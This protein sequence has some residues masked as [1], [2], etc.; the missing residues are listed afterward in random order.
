[1]STA[2]KARVAASN[3]DTEA[4]QTRLNIN[5][6]NQTAKVLRE[7]AKANGVTVTEAVRRLIGIGTI[8]TKAEGEGKDI[9]L[10]SEAGTERIVFTY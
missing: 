9:L 10:R 1:M 7:Y 4:P 5:I 3:I 8:V 2:E 6:N